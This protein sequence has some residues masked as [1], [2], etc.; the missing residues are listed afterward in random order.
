MG[1]AGVDG[2]YAESLMEYDCQVLYNIRPVMYYTNM[3][4]GRA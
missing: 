2:L 4:K 1:G 3:S